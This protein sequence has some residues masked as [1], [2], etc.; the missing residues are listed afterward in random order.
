MAAAN[1]FNEGF[2]KKEAA[3]AVASRFR[4]F[5]QQHARELAQVR[6][7]LPAAA[8][9]LWADTMEPVSLSTESRERIAP[10]DA[11]VSDN[12]LFAKAAAAMAAV[13]REAKLMTGDAEKDILPALALFGAPLPAHGRPNAAD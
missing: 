6:T 4:L 3:A 12:L 2:T 9:A 10:I 8:N 13:V 11:A 5:A 1:Q 7:A